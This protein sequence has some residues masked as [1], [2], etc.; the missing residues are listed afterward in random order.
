[1][2]KC[3]GETEFVHGVS[4]M[5]ASGM[6]GPC[7]LCSA[8]VSTV[9]LLLP[10]DDL[11]AVVRAHMAAS[12]RFRGVR[13]LGPRFTDYPTLL[14]NPRYTEALGLLHRLNISLDVAPGD[15][16]R[17]SEVV[18]LAQAFP[19]NTFV[20]N[21][22]GGTP[23]PAAFAQPSVEAA[24]RSGIAELGK[25]CPNVVIKCGGIHMVCNGW[26]DKA[27]VRAQN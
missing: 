3:V 4:A 13:L 8:I 16:S 15:T 21:H 19:D 7:A 14:T 18:E 22:C 24:W 25:T 11:E 9:D 20:L 10:A 26:K 1:M 23:G 6:Y 5:G 27:G 17:L 2:M 12:P